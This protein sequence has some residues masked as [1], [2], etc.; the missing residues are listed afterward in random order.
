MMRSWRKNAL[1]DYL[2]R[3]L[4]VLPLTGFIARYDR[5]ASRY[6]QGVYQ[7]KRSD[8][9]ASLDSTLS[10]LF[11][12]Q[13]KNLHK[14]CLV[15]FKKEMMDGLKGEEYN[16]A[17]VVKSARQKCEKRFAEAAKEAV[18]EEGADW[19]WEE[20]LELLKEEVD[21]VAN[22]CRK[23]ETKKMVN[24][25]EVIRNLSVVYFFGSLQ[26]SYSAISRSKSQNL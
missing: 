23:D 26:H 13:L 16:F 19:S 11:L 5:D 22:Q 3:F 24:L 21:N 4:C 25:I 10:P 2:C 7:R 12:G 14:T 20:E 17:D 1:S 18:V 9:I 6:H 8:L 15:A